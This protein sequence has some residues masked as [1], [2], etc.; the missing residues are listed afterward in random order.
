MTDDQPEEKSNV[1]RLVVF[2]N[3]SHPAGREV[4]LVVDEH[5]VVI[6]HDAISV[7]R[8][9]DDAGKILP[10]KVIPPSR[11]FRCPGDAFSLFKWFDE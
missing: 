1:G 6:E 3:S 7:M 2:A 11:W 9:M 4:F 8:L 10:G 5:R